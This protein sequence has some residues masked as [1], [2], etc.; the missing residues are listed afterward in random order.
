MIM[1]MFTRKSTAPRTKRT[2]KPLTADSLRELL[3]YYVG[4]FATTRS[5]AHDYARR[6]I[7]ERGWAEEA[8]ADIDGLV[9]RL[10][11][12]G[13][14]N[15]AQ[16]ARSKAEGLMRRGYGTRRVEAML[17]SAGV[18]DEDATAARDV[19]DAQRWAAA[20][21]FATKRRLGPFAQIMPDPATRQKQL[22]AFLRAGHAHKDASQLL[23]MAPGDQ[24]EEEDE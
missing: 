16:Y 19:A 3:L 1:V 8:P 5:G 14:I 24:I 23:N 2:P 6:K 9:A 11:E 18:E 15:D 20:V 12:L 22:A 7:R 4:K 21:K 10:A 13:Y 17:Y